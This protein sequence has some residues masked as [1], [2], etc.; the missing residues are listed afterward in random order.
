MSRARVAQGHIGS[1]VHGL[2]LLDDEGV[3]P[4]M[5]QIAAFSPVYSLRGC[6]LA[7][8]PS[9]MHLILTRVPNRTATFA[10][11][12]ISQTE[13]GAEMLEELGWESVSSPI[14]GP[15]GI[16]VPVYLG[17]YIFVRSLFPR[18][19]SSP[20]DLVLLNATQTPLWDPPLLSLP[21]ALSLPP[22]TS[23]L[24]I[25]ALTALANLS[26]HILATKASKALARLKSRHR[27][28]F[29][30]PGLYYRALE[31]LA[32][33]HYRLAVRK[34]VL[35]L[36]EVPLDKEVAGRIELAGEELRRR[37][38][39]AVGEGAYGQREAESLSRGYDVDVG[40]EGGRS[41]GVEGE[42]TEDDDESSG[43]EADDD[44][45]ESSKIPLQVL[46]PLV[47]VK[48]FLLA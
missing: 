22:P 12:L 24:E 37:K 33:H 19:P 14:C 8:P 15:T 45:G 48:G 11:A 26:N 4:D 23:P 2:A 47:T 16:C 7:F 44:D 36:F 30:S 42:V 46:T 13:E 31:M 18:P 21:T 29:T 35:E 27:S 41:R 10:L 32:S 17:D 20:T 9:Q 34:Y 6:A 39:R 5:V 38:S 3:L 43:D 28:L 40:E 1:T 25:T